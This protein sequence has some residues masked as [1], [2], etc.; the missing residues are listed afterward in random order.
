M[1]K[2][3][4]AVAVFKRESRG[5][6]AHRCVVW[7]LILSTFC[8]CGVLVWIN[9]STRATATNNDAA[10]TPVQLVRLSISTE[11]D[12]VRIEITADGSLGDV[13]TETRGRETIIRVPSARSLLRSS[14]AI[15]DP[16]ARVVR[17]TTGER[18]GVP[19]VE[20]AVT[21]TDD[22]MILAPRKVFNR[23]VIGVAQDS[24]RLLPPRTQNKP[25]ESTKAAGRVT[26]AA[27]FA[28]PAEV[29]LKIAEAIT[30]TDTLPQANAPATMPAPPAITASTPHA[31]IA[32]TSAL[33]PAAPP[34]PLVFRGRE[35]WATLPDSSSFFHLRSFDSP[36]VPLLFLQTPTAVAA[37]TQ[38]GTSAVATLNVVQ[39]TLAAPGATVNAWI[40]GTTAA[41]TDQIGGRMLGS[42]FLR[43]SFALGAEYNSNFFYR[44]IVGSGLG[45][46]T[47][48]PRIEYE[49]PG[50]VRALRIAYEARLRRLTNGNWANGQT[51]DFDSRL[52]LTPTV[53]LALRD[54][55][56]RSALDAREYDPAGETY[57]EGDT[58]TRNDSAVRA[59]F[60]LNARNRLAFDL[61]YNFV[62][63][64]DRYIA[65]APLFINYAELRPAIS[66]EHDVSER[67]TALAE[68]S[69][70]DTNA[71]VPLRAEF[72]GLNDRR[73]IDFMV[74]ART[75]MS[76]TSGFAFRAGFEH[77]VSPNA[78]AANDFN[79]LVFDAT[80][81]RELSEKTNFQFAALRKTQASSFNPEGG[82]AR[83]LSTGA[84]ARVERNQTEALQ[85][86]FEANYQ[87]LSFPVMIIENS[88]ASGGLFVGDFAGTRR[89]DSLYGFGL[90][91]GYR[92]S[93]LLRARLAYNFARRS[94]NIPL[95]TF[96]RN[97]LSLI[98]EFG[99][100]NDVR[101]RSF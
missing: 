45:V 33:A 40:P 69:F 34:P 38:N 48:A 52:E 2:G 9:G 50:D 16:L 22:G 17:T 8:L 91:A 25:R 29:E 76:Q 64:S 19:F 47:F 92:F 57:I 32:L 63:W 24:A 20:I 65:N 44:S 39:M 61:G 96:N 72:G 78:A 82:N 12:A 3:Q 37:L 15:N 23:L 28:S 85:L 1:Q 90:N 77:S 43:P 36:R 75:Q 14:Y 97:L 49:V 46:F 81:R 66:A 73:Q 35:I 55:F 60:T 88:T 93:D 89:R 5:R 51:L 95:L 74:G 31:P 4:R 27:P 41:E 18:D 100:R 84:A 101:G 58:F 42:G 13:V 30:T 68:I 10:V 70:T 21:R 67:T 62:R 94:S 99:R 6:I 98:F 54:H 79:G 71:S 80:Y 86:G 53:R 11:G 59:E 87:R 56:V 7:T 83:L 26:N